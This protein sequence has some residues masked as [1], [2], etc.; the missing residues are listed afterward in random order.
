MSSCIYFTFLFFCQESSMNNGVI[1][2]L[3]MFLRVERFSSNLTYERQQ[4]V[5]V[6]EFSFCIILFFHTYF[7]QWLPKADCFYTHFLFN[8]KKLFSKLLGVCENDGFLMIFF[9]I[10]RILFYFN[11]I[12]VCFSYFGG[13][14]DICFH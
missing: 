4:N 5:N 13:K 14:V 10:S 6:C 12:E 1:S 8:I 9:G 2:V 3:R 7:Y 11:A